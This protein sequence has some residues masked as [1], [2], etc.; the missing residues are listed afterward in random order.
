MAEHGLGKEHLN[1]CAH[2]GCK[3]LIEPSKHFCSE[4][5]ARASEANISGTLPGEGRQG[6]NCECGHPE[7]G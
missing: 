3:C 2:G 6:G 5:C 4:Y 1:E 7:C